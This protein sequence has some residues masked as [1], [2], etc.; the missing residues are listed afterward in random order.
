LAIVCVIGRSRVP[1]PPESTKA[2]ISN[3][4]SLNILVGYTGIDPE[5]QASWP[6]S[7]LHVQTSFSFNWKN[8][9]SGKRGIITVSLAFSIYFC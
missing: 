4:P 8:V 3:L 5:S 1:L 2:F 9:R 7:P 6:S